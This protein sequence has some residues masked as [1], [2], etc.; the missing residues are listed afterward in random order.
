[1]LPG[2]AQK[3]KELHPK[4]RLHLC[5]SHRR[6]CD[7]AAQGQAAAAEALELLSGQKRTEISA[8]GCRRKFGERASSETRPLSSKS[9]T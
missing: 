1:M 2:T 9:A 3:M 6:C 8:W 7:V 4:S 5:P